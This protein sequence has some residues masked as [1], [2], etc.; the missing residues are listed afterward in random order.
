MIM[1]K[2]L[3]GRII[4]MAFAAALMVSGTAFGQNR[5]QTL[6]AEE[7]T[8]GLENGFIET[9]T[10]GFNL[11]FVKESQTLAALQPKGAD[12]FDFTPADRLNARKG[13]RLYHL[14]DINLR[15]R[16]I[17]TQEWKRYSSALERKPVKALTV[18]S[19]RNILAAADITATF[20]DDIPLKIERYWEK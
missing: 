11:K 15:V 9:E 5:W 16:I 17:D 7:G 6:A 8:L 18:S 14:G 4:W 2:F 10:E 3:K 13:N 12:G 20:A 19:G 1:N